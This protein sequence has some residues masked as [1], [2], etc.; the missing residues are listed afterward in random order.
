MAIANHDSPNVSSIRF[1]SYPLTFTFDLECLTCVHPIRFDLPPE[2]KNNLF[3]LLFVLH[4]TQYS[5]STYMLRRGCLVPVGTQKCDIG[6]AVDIPCRC[7]WWLRAVNDLSWS[8]SSSSSLMPSFF[9]VPSVPS[10][11]DCSVRITVRRQKE[12]K[13][14]ITRAWWPFSL[15][16]VNVTG[17]QLLFVGSFWLRP[18]LLECTPSRRRNR[19]QIRQRKVFASVDVLFLSS[20]KLWRPCTVDP[21]PLSKRREKKRQE[22]PKTNFSFW[23]GR[24]VIV[25]WTYNG[26]SVW[27]CHWLQRREPILCWYI[28]YIIYESGVF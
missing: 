11:L 7:G 27:S 6:S 2:L 9:F 22:K 15:Y 18:I 19:F 3:L 26:T 25:L 16:R 23:V 14:I 28:V 13:V 1:E 20:P 10:N 17:P 24:F 12:W 4:P 21:C 8:S 5:P